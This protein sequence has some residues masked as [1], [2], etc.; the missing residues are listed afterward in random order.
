MKPTYSEEDRYKIV[1]NFIALRGK[2]LA[3]IRDFSLLTNLLSD[4]GIKVLHPIKQSGVKTALDSKTIFAGSYL[5]EPPKTVTTYSPS[6][7]EGYFNWLIFILTDVV[8]ATDE[9]KKEAVNQLFMFIFTLRDVMQANLDDFLRAGFEWQE[10]IGIIDEEMATLKGN[11]DYL[12]KHNDDDHYD[13]NKQSKEIE[14]LK[15]DSENMSLILQRIRDWEEAYQP[16]LDNIKKEQDSLG[17]VFK[18][19]GKTHAKKGNS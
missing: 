16:Y 18:G 17:N 6:D 10:R 8:P 13:Y 14:Q 3:P 11:L 9:T 19:K 1:I 15:K 7:A 4:N 5:T 12:E 2:G